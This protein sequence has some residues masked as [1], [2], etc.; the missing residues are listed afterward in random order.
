MVLFCSGEENVSVVAAP[1]AA[2]F[3][4]ASLGDPSQAGQKLLDAVIAPEGSGKTASLL[5]ASQR[6]VVKALKFISQWKNS[7][8]DIIFLQNS[9]CFKVYDVRYL[10]WIFCHVPV[11]RSDILLGYCVPLSYWL[12]SKLQIANFDTCSN[13]T[14]SDGQTYY[15]MEYTVET[16]KWRRRNASVYAVSKWVT[17]F[18]CDQL[19]SCWNGWFMRAKLPIVFI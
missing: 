12:N 1:I 11:L 6:W 9:I 2:G 17:I 14:G 7:L 15:T 10:F 16:K 13:R 3:Q 18:Q 8:S 5:D 4:L 19:N